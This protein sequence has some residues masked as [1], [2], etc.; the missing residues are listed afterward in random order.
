MLWLLLRGEFSFLNSVQ[1][2][3]PIAVDLGVTVV[4]WY[5]PSISSLSMKV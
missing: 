5:K 4:W 2:L 3:R 1:Y